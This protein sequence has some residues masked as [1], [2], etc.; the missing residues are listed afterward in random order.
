MEKSDLNQ[1]GIKIGDQVKLL[2]AIR[3]LT[4]NTYAGTELKGNE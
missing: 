4:T 3:I 2:K 1:I